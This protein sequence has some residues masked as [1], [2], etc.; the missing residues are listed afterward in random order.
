MDNRSQGMKIDHFL[1]V[2]N[3]FDNQQQNA[4]LDLLGD[5]RNSIKVANPQTEKGDATE[6]R[7]FY[8]LSHYNGSLYDNLSFDALFGSHYDSDKDED[9][10]M[11]EDLIQNTKTYKG[12]HKPFDVSISKAEVAQLKSQL[13]YDSLLFGDDLIQKHS[14][15]D[16]GCSVISDYEVNESSIQGSRVEE[17]VLRKRKGTRS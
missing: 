1:R 4:D 12:D 14:Y 16:I 3:A 6:G 2:P 13:K 15:N 17:R 5:N 10:S 11:K 9:Y 8:N 7:E